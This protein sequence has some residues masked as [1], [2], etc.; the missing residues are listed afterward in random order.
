MVFSTQIGAYEVIVLQVAVLKI[1]GLP[2]RM[3][4][5]LQLDRPHSPSVRVRQLQTERV[6]TGYLAL[7]PSSYAR[8]AFKHKLE[9]DYVRFLNELDV[10]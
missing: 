2:Y 3:V 1:S 8:T 7:Y 10:V 5:V 6:R 4:N 9:N